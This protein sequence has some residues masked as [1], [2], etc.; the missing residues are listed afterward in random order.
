M[1]IF[2]IFFRSIRDSFKSVFRNFSLSLA[3]IICII[4]TLLLVSVTIVLSFNLNNFTKEVEKDL[5]I[6]A[7]VDREISLE[8][9]DYVETQIKSIDNIASY[10]IIDK[11]DIRDDLMA[12]SEAY[13][14]LLAK[15]D[16]REENPLLDAIHIKV[17]DV[18]YMSD[19]A[20][21]I[22]EIADIDTVKYGEGLVEQLIG[23]FETIRSVSMWLVL[24]LI[25]ITA[26]LI[27]NTIKVTIFSRKREIEIMR[28][29]GA[30]NTNIK[31]PFIIEGLFLGIFGSIVPII[32]TIIGYEELFV[33]FSTQN[34]ASF[35]QLIEPYPF[36]IY[37]AL[38]LLGI[39]A[40]VGM[41]GSLF[42]VRKHL[43]I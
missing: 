39:G 27:T 20:L 37:I 42:A 24:A 33:I 10:E 16:T 41:I 43:K 9:L 38:L 19:V 1:R 31:I 8:G 26:F 11:M 25:L 3:S 28:L 36:S 22:E 6:V 13:N 30:S 35:L 29:V 32:A 2:R 12:S 18:N 34:T 4:I 21:E 15:Y 40:T 23:T 17:T 5:T 7:F 14:N